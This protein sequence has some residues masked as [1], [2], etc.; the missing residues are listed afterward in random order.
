MFELLLSNMGFAKRYSFC[1]K[2]YV[3]QYSYF[4]KAIPTFHTHMALPHPHFHG[5]LSISIFIKTQLHFHQIIPQTRIESKFLG[6]QAN[7]LHMGCENTMNVKPPIF[8]GSLVTGN[9]STAILPFCP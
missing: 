1:P 8:R 6:Q 7:R 5:N 2:V 9:I 4:Y 3:L